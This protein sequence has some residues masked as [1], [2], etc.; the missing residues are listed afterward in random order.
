MANEWR[1]HTATRYV[2]DL[3][4]GATANQR[5]GFVGGVANELGEERGELVG[6]GRQRASDR[7]VGERARGS[8]RRQRRGDRRNR[9]ASHRAE[10]LLEL[11]Q[12]HTLATS[13][14]I[15][16]RTTSTGHR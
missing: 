5:H 3:R 11:E 8:R 6:G 9:D 1:L 15:V 4:V 16:A 13:G 10:E 12:A 14:A 7:R 2:P